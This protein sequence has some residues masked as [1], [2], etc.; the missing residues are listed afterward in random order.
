MW[1]AQRTVD[2]LL[3]SRRLPHPVRSQARWGV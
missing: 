3:S 2:D 1:T